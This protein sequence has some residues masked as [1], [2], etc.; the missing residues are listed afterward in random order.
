MLLYRVPTGSFMAALNAMR[1]L[2]AVGIG[3]GIMLRFFPTVAQEYRSIRNAQKFRGVGVGFWHML[4]HLPQTLSC[5][6]LP[7]VIRVNRIAE[8]LSASVTVRG[9]RFHN[10]VVSFRSVRF[11]GRDALLLGGG[12]T[13]GAGVL[14]LERFMVGVSL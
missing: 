10:E 1:L 9:V 6:L 11:S 4:A 14:L 2:K 12:L 5:I 8:E 7:L 13:A 3:I